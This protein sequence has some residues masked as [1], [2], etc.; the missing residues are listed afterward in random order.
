MMRDQMTQA[1]MILMIAHQDMTVATRGPLDHVADPGADADD[2]DDRNDDRKGDP[3][4]VE[5]VQESP[6]PSN[7]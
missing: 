1:L 3:D 7:R 4:I 2:D 6:G 5:R